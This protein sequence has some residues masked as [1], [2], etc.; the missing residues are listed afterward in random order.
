MVSTDTT[1]VLIAARSPRSRSGERWSP[2][3]RG[4]SSASSVSWRYWPGAQSGA[5]AILDM[6]TA[7]AFSLIV[8]VALP[9]AHW[10]PKS[11]FGR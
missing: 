4:G 5:C 10:P 2:R 6:D 9:V 7:V 8:L 1:R 11:M 3:E